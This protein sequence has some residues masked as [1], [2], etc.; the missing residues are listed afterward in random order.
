MMES[1]RLQFTSSLHF[2]QYIQCYNYTLGTWLKSSVC[3]G[4]L[5]AAARRLVALPCAAAACVGLLAALV[6]LLVGL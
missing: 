5:L 2:R 1:T 4:G 6:L 3:L